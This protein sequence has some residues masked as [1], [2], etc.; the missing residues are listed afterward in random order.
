[1]SKTRMNQMSF[2]SEFFDDITNAAMIGYYIAIKKRYVNRVS[3]NATEN[4][5]LEK[6]YA[7]SYKPKHPRHSRNKFPS[8]W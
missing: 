8:G 6:E 3:I 2:T 5:T 4:M 1:M 7:Q